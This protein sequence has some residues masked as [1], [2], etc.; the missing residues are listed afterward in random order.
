MDNIY[1]VC[2][3]T[4]EIKK[5]MVF[6]GKSSLNK[7]KH[8]NKFLS[9]YFDQEEIDGIIKD[10]IVVEFVDYTIH[11]DDT[12][13]DVKK[14]IILAFNK[15]I[16]YDEIYLYYIEKEQLVTNVVFNSLTLDK[17]IEI[18]KEILAQFLLNFVDVD[19]DTIEV[20]EIYTYNDIL[21]LI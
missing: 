8:D 5:I 7:S 1:K 20:K 10:K 14:K 16:S 19:I 15:D 17:E 4:D 12:I 11:F 9:G 18:S 21:S 13:E 2:Y 6:N 3:L